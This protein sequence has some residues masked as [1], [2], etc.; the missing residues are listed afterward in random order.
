MQ[1]VLQSHTHAGAGEGKR[2]IRGNLTLGN[3]GNTGDTLDVLVL[4]NGEGGRGGKGGGGGGGGSS[5]GSLTPQAVPLKVLIAQ[6]G[7]ARGGIQ[8]LLASMS[9]SLDA[10]GG[11]PINPNSA[12]APSAPRAHSGG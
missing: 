9:E 3:T 10:N 6:V 2:G 1:R 12:P 7:A 8:D 4:G 5:L 11:K